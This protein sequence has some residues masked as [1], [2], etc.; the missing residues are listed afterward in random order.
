M[1]LMARIEMNFNL[2]DKVNRAEFFVYCQK[3]D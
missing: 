1:Q 3:K 2:K